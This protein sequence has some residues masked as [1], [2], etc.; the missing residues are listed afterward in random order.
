MSKRDY[1]MEAIELADEA[2]KARNEGDT[3]GAINLYRQAREYA[4]KGNAPVFA[5][6]MTDNITLLSV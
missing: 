1:R 6:M 3:K 2:I 4:V 5:R